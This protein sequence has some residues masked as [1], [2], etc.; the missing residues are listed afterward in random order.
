MLGTVKSGL[1]A[2][3]YGTGGASGGKKK[4]LASRLM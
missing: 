3:G 4:S 1:D 2:V